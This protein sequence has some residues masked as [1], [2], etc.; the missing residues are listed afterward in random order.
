MYTMYEAVQTLWITSINPPLYQKHK[1][2]VEVKIL[3]KSHF[4]VNITEGKVFVKDLK[5]K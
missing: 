1:L 3:V 2:L 5:E 4:L